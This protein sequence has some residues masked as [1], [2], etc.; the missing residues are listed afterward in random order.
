MDDQLAEETIEHLKSESLIRAKKKAR[1]R[2]L[3]RMLV[4][5]LL[6]G[7]VFFLG[8]YG[9]GRIR[10]GVVLVIVWLAYAAV[11]TTFEYLYSWRSVGRAD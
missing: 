4:F 7:P 3:V 2:E 8:E 5:T 6:A 9:L 11:D 1:R 10:D